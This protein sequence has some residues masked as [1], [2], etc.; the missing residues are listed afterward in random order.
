MNALLLGTLLLLCGH[1]IHGAVSIP[2]AEKRGA[3]ILV[4][5]AILSKGGELEQ[6]AT[7]HFKL[8]V[9]L[10]VSL[11]ASVHHA[12]ATLLGRVTSGIYCVHTNGKYGRHRGGG[13]HRRQRGGMGGAGAQPKVRAF[14]VAARSSD[15]KILFYDNGKQRWNRTHLQLKRKLWVASENWKS[16]TG[17]QLIEI[18]RAFGRKSLQHMQIARLPCSVPALSC[19]ADDLVQCAARL[20][21]HETHELVSCRAISST[22]WV[23]RFDASQPFLV[24][25]MQNSV[26][27]LHNADEFCLAVPP[28]AKIY[29]RHT[30]FV[31]NETFATTLLDWLRNI[32]LHI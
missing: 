30:P 11:P 21:E 2:C 8:I 14:N 23:V 16:V 9:V 27:V 15:G 6:H 29:V 31:S 3:H 10:K 4:D 22:D 18:I 17:T 32:L 1:Q 19:S 26:M 5:G 28:P 13:T 20:A 25:L 7:R 12:Y 24:R